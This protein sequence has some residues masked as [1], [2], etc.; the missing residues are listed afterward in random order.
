MNNKPISNPSKSI[1]NIFRRYNLT[2]FVVVIV[3]GLIFCVLILTNIMNRPPD[4]NVNT[5]SGGTTQ[6]DQ[7]TIDS[8][9][10]YKASSDN[11]G[12][13]VLPS[14]GRINPFSE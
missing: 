5:S 6:F 12:T 8:L 14:S 3:G 11:L 1:T 13:Q 7:A 4:D 2:L 9:S 10:K